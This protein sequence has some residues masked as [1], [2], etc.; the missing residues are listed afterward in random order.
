MSK[1]VEIGLFEYIEDEFASEIRGYVN[2][3][4]NWDGKNI[5][6]NESLKMARVI[7]RAR[8]I[9]QL[10]FVI[11]GSKLNEALRVVQEEKRKYGKR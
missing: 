1:P 4:E 9:D 6:L 10:G 2:P 5:T 11:D 8:C 3:K 7:I